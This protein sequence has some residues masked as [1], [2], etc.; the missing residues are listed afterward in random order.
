[1][2]YS[3]ATFNRQELPTHHGLRALKKRTL[4]KE[5]VKL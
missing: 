5:K 2:N 1:M 4:P 3:Y